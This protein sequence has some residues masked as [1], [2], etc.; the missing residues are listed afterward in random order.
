[1]NLELFSTNVQRTAAV[2]VAAN[3]CRGMHQDCIPM[4]KNFLPIL[5]SLLQYSDYVIV[6]QVCL[7]FVYLADSFKNNAA[8]L[9]SV[10]TEAVLRRIL[11]L[12]HVNTLLL[13]FLGTVAEFSPQLGFALLTM[14]FI[15]TL[16]FTLDIS[17]DPECDKK[18]KGIAGILNKL[19]FDLS[20]EDPHSGAKSKM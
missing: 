16:S 4:V 12:S 5:E 7:C 8:H 14:G 11:T 6:E 2:K 19:V 18:I 1:M 13:D 15:D 10:L 17:T 9:Q 3:C 20:Q